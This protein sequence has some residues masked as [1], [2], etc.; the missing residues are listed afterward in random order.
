MLVSINMNS[1]LGTVVFKSI[2]QECTY[3][4]ISEAAVRRCEV[5]CVD[6]VVH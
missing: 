4:I 2:A 1:V 3:D 5:T 6:Y